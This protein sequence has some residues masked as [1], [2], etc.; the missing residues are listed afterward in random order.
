VKSV[1]PVLRL[2]GQLDPLL[3]GGIAHDITDFILTSG[4]NLLLQAGAEEEAIA[5]VHMGDILVLV[6]FQESE[7]RVERGC[8]A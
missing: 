2:R 4:R 6:R 1:F 8:A 5:G 7:G 3:R